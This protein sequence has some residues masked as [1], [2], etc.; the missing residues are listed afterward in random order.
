[1]ETP[2]INGQDTTMKRRTFLK[3][4][5]LAALAGISNY[6]TGAAEPSGKPNILIIMTDQ[7]FADCMSCVM[8]K[9]H[10][11]TP[12]MDK[13]AENGTRFTRAYAPNPLCKPMRTSMFTGQYPH[14]TGVQNNSGRKLD[15][16]KFTFMGKIFR[17]AGY[18]TAYFG[19]W[20]IAISEK[21]KDVHG[22]SKLVGKSS[23]INPGPAAEFLRKPPDKPFLAVA[24]FLGPHEICEWSR[25]QKIPGKQLPDPPP[26]DQRPPL[27]ENFDPPKNETDIITHMRK[28]YQAHR[29]FPVGNYTVADW[30]RHIWGYYRLIERVDGYVGT[31]MKALRDSGQEK[32][33][34][35]VF[36]SDH[37]DC[38]GAHH[39]NQKTVFYD[40]SARVPF[41][42]SWK[43]TTP[44][45]TSDV[46]LN[47][48]VDV[49]PTI[50]DFAGIKV[51]ES[52]S[53]KSLKLPA[54]GKDPEWKR[55]FIVCQN[56][57]VQCR[58]V[59]GK[60]LK[61]HGRMVRSDR[62]KY[63]L[64]SEGEQ[65]ESLVDMKKDPGE[66]V[67]LAGSEEHKKILQQHR[68]YLADWCKKH[69]D[70]FKVAT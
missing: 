65:R 62:Y 43:G 8:G 57:M 13:L 20:H 9:K 12:H 49:I 46:L 16:A 56:H 37:G 41:I 21:Q 44:G 7:Q 59:D 55:D 4:S 64:Y 50:C 23:Q 10:L 45:G 63:C 51:P 39:W 70:D 35:V 24:S 18:K 25:K 5:G 17:D 69:K 48:G 19:K 68:Q 2:L 40:E 52:M 14:V 29:L 3:V 54:M 58:P 60:D 53:G 61:P 67:N 15:P 26:V 38:H 33:T 42:I 27:R 47:T 34:V 11:H 1:M 31:V 36:L 32:K 28:A 30:R 6:R 22:F 66:M